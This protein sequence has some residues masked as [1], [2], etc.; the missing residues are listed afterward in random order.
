MCSRKFVSKRVA[1]LHYQVYNIAINL[2]NSKKKV[3][4]LH[5]NNEM[6]QMFVLMESIFTNIY[7]YRNI[8]IEN[9]IQ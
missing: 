2:M 7:V 1:L 9:I 4:L 8:C 6:I 5:A 3:L